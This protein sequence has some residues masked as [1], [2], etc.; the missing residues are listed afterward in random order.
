MALA[1]ME[2][3]Q[4]VALEEAPE[5]DFAAM[6]AGEVSLDQYL[7]DKDLEFPRYSREQLAGLRR[8]H[9]EGHAILQAEPYLERL[10]TIHEFLAAGRSRAEVESQPGLTEVYAA[11][12]RAS[13]ALINFFRLAHTA[14]FP[15]VVA[16]VQA[17]ARADAARFRLRDEL[18]AQ[19]LAPLAARFASLY[20]EAGYI[21]LYLVKSLKRLLAGAARLKPVFLLARLALP[22]IGRPRPLGPG[23]L[24][25]LG[26]VFGRELTQAQEDLLAAR[27]LIYIQLL[28]KD[29]LAPG[30]DP[31]PHLHNEVAAWHLTAGLSVKDCQELYP[32]VRRLAPAAAAAEVRRF[33]ARPVPR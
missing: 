7:A 9:R 16:A 26:Y 6:L 19:A 31:A 23:D 15:K 13:Q 5:P 18:R 14:P 12:S 2:R 3:H 32:R 8:L 28:H 29:E 20:V 22:A 4:A 10:I 1:A 11:E 27:S 30:E 17:F 21:H 33:L 24:L 25:T